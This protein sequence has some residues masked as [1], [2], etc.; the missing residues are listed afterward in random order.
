MRR[1]EFIILLSSASTILPLMVRAQQLN[2]TPTIGF[3]GSTSQSAATPWAAAFQRRLRE[4]GWDEGRNVAIEYRWGEGLGDRFAE[5]AAEFVRLKVDVI[6]TAGGAVPAAKRETSVIPIVFAV[7]S[8]PVGGG[9]VDSLA[10]PGGNVTGLSLQLGDTSSKRL[11]FLREIL[12]RVRRLAVLANAGY[13]ASVLEMQEVQTLSQGLGLEVIRL[14]VR[15][16]ED[17]AP[18][19]EVVKGQADAVYVAADP[20][21]TNNRIHIGALALQAK[22]PTVNGAREYVEAGGLISYGASYSDLY[23]RAAEFVDKILRGEKPSNIP[24]EQPTKFELV[25]NL[26]TARALGLR[27]PEAFLLRADEVIE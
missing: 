24:I 13:R 21:L 22:L 9:L 17:I 14:E 15:R 7:A 10:H 1:R 8:D 11:E 18:S 16:M 2:K 6:V 25:V 26:N 12:P 4:L 27:I 3:L 19:M 5:I 20:L 23:R